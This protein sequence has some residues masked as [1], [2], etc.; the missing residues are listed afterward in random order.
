MEAMQKKDIEVLYCF[1]N[2]DELVLMNLA[3][4]DKKNL[5]SVENQLVED[6]SDTSTVDTESKLIYFCIVNKSIFCVDL[7]YNNK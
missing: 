2:F 6:K 5:K 3:Q 7:V 4:F 1:E